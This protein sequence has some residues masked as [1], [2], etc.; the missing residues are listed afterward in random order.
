MKL[1]ISLDIE[2]H[3]NYYNQYS[4]EIKPELIN[5]LNENNINY[6]IDSLIKYIELYNKS[7]AI[8][9]KLTWL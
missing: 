5:W 3:F 4:Y 1:I 7:D 9:F 2:K 8:K 6:Y